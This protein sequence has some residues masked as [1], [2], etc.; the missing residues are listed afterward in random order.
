MGWGWI[1][2]DC[3]DRGEIFQPCCGLFCNT[4]WRSGKIEGSPKVIDQWISKYMRLIE[5][6]F[7]M[8]SLRGATEA[9]FY[10]TNLL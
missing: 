3:T 4:S 6:E 1:S 10:R 7:P 2:S 5:N 9:S 8:Q